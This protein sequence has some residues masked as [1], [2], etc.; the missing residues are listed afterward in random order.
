MNASADPALG[1][2][3]LECNAVD[4]QSTACSNVC[5]QLL[6]IPAGGGDGK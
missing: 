4:P 2:R 3:G 6:Y 1:G 5:T